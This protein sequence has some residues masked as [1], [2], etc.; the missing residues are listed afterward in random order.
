[1]ARSAERLGKSSLLKECHITGVPASWF[2]EEIKKEV[3]AGK[4][5]KR[6]TSKQLVMDNQHAK[7]K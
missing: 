4:S 6:T 3:V 5:R 2:S 7:H 1:M